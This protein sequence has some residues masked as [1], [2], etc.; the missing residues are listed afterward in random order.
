MTT[1]PE[2]DEAKVKA[3]E[4]QIEEKGKITFFGLLR[5]ATNVEEARAVHNRLLAKGW[6]YDETCEILKRAD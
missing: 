1:Y 4:A 3:V 6:K 5:L 2:V